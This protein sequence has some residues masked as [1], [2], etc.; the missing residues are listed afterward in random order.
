MIAVFCY[1]MFDK[2][3]IYYK[4]KGVYKKATSI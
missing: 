1:D 3:D 4:V 2:K